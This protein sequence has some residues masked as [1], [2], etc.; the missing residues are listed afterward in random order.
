MLADESGATMGI[1][2]TIVTHAET[3]ADAQARRTGKKQAQ[4]APKRLKKRCKALTH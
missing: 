2:I 1:Q 3:K 4:A